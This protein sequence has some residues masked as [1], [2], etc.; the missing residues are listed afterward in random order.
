M[1][2]FSPLRL[3]QI[4]RAQ[5]N[6]I[7]PTGAG[8][9]L[10]KPDNKISQN[11]FHFDRLHKFTSEQALFHSPLQSTLLPVQPPYKDI[12]Q[13]REDL[14]TVFRS[15][16]PF[17]TLEREVKKYLASQNNVPQDENEKFRREILEKQ[18]KRLFNRWYFDIHQRVE[19]TIPVLSQFFFSTLIDCAIFS[20]D[21]FLFFHC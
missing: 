13:L 21:S 15:F 11:R 12:N 19:V 1:L 2:R 3:A 14:R 7:S 20:L 5:R 4:L 8:R 16:I 6:V 18:A 10:S 9:V 17:K